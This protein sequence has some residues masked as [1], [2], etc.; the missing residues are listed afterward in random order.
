MKKE[1]SLFDFLPLAAVSLLMLRIL[2]GQRKMERFYKFI[3]YAVVF[4]YALILVGLILILT[5]RF[6]HGA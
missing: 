3:I 4:G 1:T 5:M 2:E 6:A